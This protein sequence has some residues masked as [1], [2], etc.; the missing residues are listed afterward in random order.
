MERHTIHTLH[1]TAFLGWIQSG[2]SIGESASE[3][4]GLKFF[5]TKEANHLPKITGEAADEERAARADADD[6]S[7]GRAAETQM[8]KDQEHP[9]AHDFREEGH[10]DAGNL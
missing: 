1:T 4:L 8:K 7:L 2:A 10:G 5:C 6:E 9:V 3:K